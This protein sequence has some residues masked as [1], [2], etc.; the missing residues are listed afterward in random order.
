VVIIGGGPAGSFLAIDLLRYSKKIG[1]SV[2]VII[3]EKKKSMNIDEQKRS[4][5]HIG[6]CN[7]CAGGLSPK[8]G[9]ALKK[10]GL[11][12]PVGIIMDKVV[13]INIFADWKT[14]SLDVLREITSVY[15]GSR[16]GGRSDSIYNFDSFLLESAAKEGAKIITAEVTELGYA[17]DGRVV[18]TYN[19][20]GQK[21][22]S[23]FGK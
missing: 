23:D 4:E 16:P 1:L 12:L 7:Y 18:L 15:R 8:I 19:G 5:C 13:I 10:M 14:I 22:E 2:A 9:D 17:V 6:E 3:M 11:H 20:M 21:M